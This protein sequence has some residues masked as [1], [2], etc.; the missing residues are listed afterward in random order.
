[1]VDGEQLSRRAAGAWLGALVG[2]ALYL[3]WRGL[4][5]FLPHSTHLDALV[6]RNQ[7]EALRAE[8]SSGQVESVG[9]W[10][11]YLLARL[12]ALLPDALASLEPLQL[13]DHLVRA[14]T[15]LLQIRLVSVA[16]SVLIVLGTYLLARKFT[17][18]VGSLFAA[19]LLATSTLNISFA[20]QERPHALAASFV[21]LT[22][23]A[24]MRL[25]RRPTLGSC[26]LVGSA[27]ALA[28]GALQNGAAVG[29]PIAAAVALAIARRDE[30]RPPFAR[31]VA[32]GALCIA[33]IAVGVRIC[34]PFH[35]AGERAYLS[36]AEQADGTTFN[37]SGQT[38][39]LEHFNGSG[40]AAVI[41]TLYSY[42]PHVLVLCVAALALSLL[43]R[44]ER[45][46][47]SDRRAARKIALAYVVPYTLV[48]GL[49][50]LTW[51]RYV[52]PLEPFF[53]A[54]AAWGVVRIHARRPRLA[55]ATAALSLVFAG[56]CA[57][58][59]GAV[60]AAPDTF[61]LA[62]RWIR[63]H[64]RA[65]VDPIVT[66][67]YIDLPLLY[68]DETLASRPALTYWTR[69]QLECKPVAH[70]GSRYDV[71]LPKDAETARKEWG[72]DPLEYLRSTQTRFVVVQHV[73]DNFRHKLAL[74]TRR[75]LAEHAVLR[76]RISPRTTDSGAH[77]GLGIRRHRETLS[78]PFVATLFQHARM[79][80]TLE[81]YELPRP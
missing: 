35:F 11:P 52:M 16:G 2:A 25:Q 20:Q 32:G 44:R 17:T 76:E 78:R 62:A 23:L 69:Y 9:E 14:A 45:A 34:Y 41:G 77:A 28:I 10:Y 3:R 70:V 5:Y 51:E 7:V 42:S 1:M 74:R 8:G 61:T 75:A 56:A 37:L 47:S 53:A 73:S 36:F 63:E 79:G 24:A 27:A 43:E 21:V 66:L 4:S 67:P 30:Q 80:P 64:A 60:R 72:D 57:W 31:V 19:A 22:V 71:V 18:R 46:S 58:R 49:H 29:F 38:V 65:E 26:A 81:I 48:I 33:L 50:S 59:L 68:R 54:F 13:E 15:P 12:T 6:I 55:V 40:F 39:Y